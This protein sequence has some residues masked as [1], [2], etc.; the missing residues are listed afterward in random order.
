MCHRP[1]RLSTDPHP[2]AFC[3]RGG[4]FKTQ[5]SPAPH[6]ESVDCR[7]DGW[8]RR[9]RSAAGSMT[10][11]KGG[12]VVV[13]GEPGGLPASGATVDDG[14]RPDNTGERA[15]NISR[16]AG[17]REASAGRG[18]SIS[19]EA[20]IER[21]HPS[22]TAAFSATRKCQRFAASG[23]GSHR[24]ACRSSNTGKSLN[25]PRQR[26]P[27]EMIVTCGNRQ[28]SE[29]CRLEEMPVGQNTK[30]PIFPLRLRLTRL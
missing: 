23:V 13:A 28:P 2:Q 16:E 11:S 9:E 29:A 24:R 17:I 8:H 7:G 1:L 26:P 30:H 5:W 21:G 3:V 18:C 27:R 10:G 19:R 25:L 12:G 20:G 4:A 15:D 6:A 22:T 14:R